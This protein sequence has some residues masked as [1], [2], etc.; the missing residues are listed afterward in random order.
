MTGVAR[1]HGG[2]ATREYK[3]PA[4]L[5]MCLRGLVYVGPLLR[6]CYRDDGCQISV[7]ALVSLACDT[8]PIHVDPE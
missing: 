7:T 1:W 5:A 2:E 3:P 4:L 8:A 6:P